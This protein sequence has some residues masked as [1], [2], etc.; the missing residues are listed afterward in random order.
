MEQPSRTSY[1]VTSSPCL[2]RDSRCCSTIASPGG[3]PRCYHMAFS[4]QRL[5][6]VLLDRAGAGLMPW[7]CAREPPL[8]RPGRAG[9]HPVSSNRLEAEWKRSEDADAIVLTD[10]RRCQWRS[11]RI[12]HTN[13]IRLVGERADLCGLGPAEGSGFGTGG[14][15]AGRD[16]AAEDESH[17]A[18]GHVLVDA[19]EPFGLHVQA[20]LLAYL[21]AEA[22]P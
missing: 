15:A 9:Q 7:R 16:A 3:F 21:A 11:E 17:D 20:G 19:G 1:L 8:P 13:R 18:A 22:G 2:R 5:T 4:M 10:G 14:K 6:T 12:E